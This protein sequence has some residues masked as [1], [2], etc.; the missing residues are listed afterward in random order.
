MG[1]AE[2]VLLAAL[3][4]IFGGFP[5]ALIGAIGA[6]CLGIAL[7]IAFR[8]FRI[9]RGEVA[10]GRVVDVKVSRDSESADSYAPIFEFVPAGSSDPVR[11]QSHHLYSHR[12]PEIGTQVM[13]RYDPA[14]PQR[15]EVAGIGRQLA[16]FA[17]CLMLGAGTLYTAWLIGG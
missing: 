1:G 10:P 14:N 5:Q 8:S 17:V 13:V 4:R 15:A 7:F 16:G 12:R 9:A 2:P 3:G 6:A 11:V